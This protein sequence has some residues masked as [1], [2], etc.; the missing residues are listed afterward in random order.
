[1][2]KLIV[3]AQVFQTA[4]WHRG[5]GKYSLE[6]LKAIRKEIEGDETFSLELILST[7]I[8]SD[9]EMERTLKKELGHVKIVRLDLLPDEIGNSKIP[10]QN[11][12]AIDGYINQLN[13]GSEK[14][15]FLILS[16]MQGVIYP[17]FPSVEGVQ[18]LL[19]FYDIIPF[20]F[21]DIY[22]RSGITRSEYLPRIGEILRADT[23]LAISKTV[24]NDLSFYLGISKD[25]IVSIDGGAIP[26]SNKEKVVKLQKPFILMPTGNDLRKN[27]KRAII[28]FKEFNATHGDAYSLVITSFFKEH[29]QAAL[30]ALCDDVIFTGNVSGEELNYLYNKSVALLFPSEYEGLGMPI[31]EAAEKQKPIAC[32]NIS[33]FREMSTKAFTYFDPYSS[34]SIAEALGVVVS[35]KKIDTKE[36]RRLLDMYTWQHS[37]QGV[38]QAISAVQ[39]A[40][41]TENGV[42]VCG[43]NP[44]G[45]DTGSLMQE[46]HAELSRV[47]KIKSYF[48][49]PPVSV[50]E[51]RMNF[52]PYSY[53][54]QSIQPGVDYSILEENE[55]LYHLDDGEEFAEVLLV[56]LARPGVA[57][58]YNS[59]LTTVWRTMVS[60]GLVAS[61]R[62][63]AEAS[64]DE[65]LGLPIGAGLGTLL[66]TQDAIVLFD[67]AQYIA[68][69]SIVDSLG[70]NV[71]LALLD[72]PAPSAVYPEALPEKTIMK[73][74]AD[75]VLDD[76]MYPTD[77]QLNTVL[78]K[79][80]K[81]NFSNHNINW[82]LFYRAAGLGAL[83]SS[84]QYQ[85]QDSDGARTPKE[86]RAHRSKLSTNQV[87]N[88]LND[89][90]AHHSI[91]QFS[92]HLSRIFSREE[93]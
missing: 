2:K 57:I 24:A 61:G 36:Y 73:I 33:V 18:K 45:S 85:D 90:H 26:H 25:R 83:S 48:L 17:T 6:L 41:E 82:K 59:S 53:P 84:S 1:M 74:D 5:M 32:S 91:K 47:I 27:N 12:Q 37:A 65:Q 66:R 39:P 55:R 54:V 29:E 92:Q 44:S 75:K 3:D 76:S 56:A 52:L 28:G 11:R 34:G 23:Y 62:L 7:Q 79:T 81:V 69:Q 35:Q 10:V 21:H 43:P 8:E 86:G 31:L 71:R 64:L 68:L 70:L 19:L 30:R 77:Y 88:L 50:D 46:M 42:V 49:T 72:R 38:L 93:Y 67:E 40:N 51:K 13:I 89:M 87:V 16:A 60:R 4:A 15:H 9:A 22:L 14:I 80:M 63:H 58:L 78:G 20:M